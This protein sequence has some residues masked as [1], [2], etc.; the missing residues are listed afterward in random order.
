MAK[1]KWPRLSESLTAPRHPRVCQ[2]CGQHFASVDEPGLRGWVE[3]DEN[4]KPEPIVVMLC[5][6]CSDRL[7]EPHPRLYRALERWEPF[8]G[9]IEVCVDCQLRDGTRC[10][11][12]AA[13][14]NGGAGVALRFP[15][16]DSAFVCRRGGRGGL[17]HIFKGPVA[18]CDRREPGAG[19]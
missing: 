6:E 9:A 10:T 3:H 14:A 7:I 13:K 4:D 18:N 19:A 1:G 17:V 5:K 12:P 11:S 16:P 8:P 15:R 2:S